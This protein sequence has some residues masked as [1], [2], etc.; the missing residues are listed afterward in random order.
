VDTTSNNHIGKIPAGYCQ[1]R[2]GGR[3]N[4]IKHTNVAEG[5]IKGAYSRFLPGH[6]KRKP[7]RY[8]L[9]DTGMDTPC[10]IWKLAK[11]KD[12]Y[13]AEW[14]PAGRQVRAHR[15]SYEAKY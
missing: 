6:N 3:T 14:D 13:G 7:D 15:R 12:G 1:C 2:C 4:I 5:R 11:D 8:T 10:M 9:T